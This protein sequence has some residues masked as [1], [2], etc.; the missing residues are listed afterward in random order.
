MVLSSGQAMRGD[1]HNYFISSRSDDNP[2]GNKNRSREHRHSPDFHHSHCETF[3]SSAPE[4]EGPGS[5]CSV[6]SLR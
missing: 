5:G 2:R 4:L 3:P 1:F 6:P